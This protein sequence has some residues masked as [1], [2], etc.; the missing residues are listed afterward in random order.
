MKVAILF[1]FQEGP[2]GGGNQFLKA[3]R[4]HWQLQGRYAESPED[5]DAVLFNSHHWQGQLTRLFMLKRRN[6]NLLIVHRIDGPISIVRGQ[7]IERLV[8]HAIGKF[9]QLLAD[10]TIYQSRWSRSRCHEFGLS[11]DKPNTVIINAPNPNLFFPKTTNSKKKHDK[12]RIVMTSWSSNWL[13]GFDIY[14][15]LD[16]H[17]DFTRYKLTFIGNSPVKF[18]NIH[19]IPPLTSATLAK[20]L[21]NH[22]LFLTASIDDPCSNSLIE[23]IHSGLYPIVRNS[24]GHPEIV[25]NRGTLF[26]DTSDVLKSI[27]DATAQCCFKQP[28][29]LPSM[30]EVADAYYQFIWDLL[31]TQAHHKTFNKVSSIIGIIKFILFNSYFNILRLIHRI[32]YK[33]LKLWQMDKS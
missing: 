8:D 31:Q 10:A 16:Q 2:W 6:P 25:G 15:Y 21:R 26:Y 20:E 14:Q 17:L 29:N 18:S 13:K 30:E 28:F 12:I 3:L 5:A 32:K 9:N 19:V 23:A 11:I 7:N 27:D 4:D 24:G 33:L 1:D 22:D